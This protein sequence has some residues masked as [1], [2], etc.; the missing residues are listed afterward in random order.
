MFQ[1]NGQGL[2]PIDYVIRILL[3][4]SGTNT[5]VVPKKCFQKGESGDKVYLFV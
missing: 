4:Q 3:T 2:Q 5:A 1:I